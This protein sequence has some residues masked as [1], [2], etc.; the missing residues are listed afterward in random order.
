MTK[1]KIPLNLY[2]SPMIANLILII[3]VVTISSLNIYIPAAVNIQQDFFVSEFT[4]KVSLLMS[5]IT[6]FLCSIPIGYYAD[7][8]G[9]QKFYLAGMITYMCGAAI[10]FIAHSMTFFFL[11]Q[12]FLALATGAINVLTATILADLFKGIE[13]AKYMGVFSAL[14]PAVSTLSPL[15]GGQILHHTGWR[16]IFVYLFLTMAAI[17]IYA[18]SR[19]PE[20]K[21]KTLTDKQK[22]FYFFPELMGLFKKPLVVRLALANALTITVSAIFTIN[23]P[24][25]FINIYGFSP[26]TYSFLVAVPVIF[27]FI[28]ALTYRF[29][30][31]YIGPKKGLKIGLIPSYF[32]IVAT[33]MF[34]I[35]WIPEDPYLIVATISIF[36]IGSSFIISS[37]ITMLL[38][39][40][41]TNKG[42]TNSVISLVRNA[43][44]VS[45]LL[46]VSY[47]V[48]DSVFPIYAAIL[49]IALT[50]ILLIRKV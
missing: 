31:P 14:F 38:D 49:L 6:S 44:L 32:T 18:W 9:R 48:V 17:T 46:L 30:V 19:I 33:S 50:I 3:A 40:S 22:E 35:G 7:R 20:T 21:Q 42:L 13:L 37:T 11:G 23:S 43:T 47:F 12:F 29:I 34:L 1:N 41:T 4:L 10:C 28:G 39:A 25:L 26:V 16:Y 36:S 45:I 24:F 5:P 15:L 2:S 27:Q 8:Y